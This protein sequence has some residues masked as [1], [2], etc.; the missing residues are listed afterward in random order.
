[1]E[2]QGWSEGKGLGS[3]IKGLADALEN[4]GQHPRDRSGFG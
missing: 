1:M 4:E 3:T 2:T